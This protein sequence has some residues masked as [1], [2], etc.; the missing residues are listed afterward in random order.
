MD[1]LNEQIAKRILSLNEAEE[2]GYVLDICF[3]DGLKEFLGFV[4]CDRETEN[5]NFIPFTSVKAQ[6]Q[7]YLFVDN[8]EA[9]EPFFDRQTN[10]P[11]RKRV[12][13]N[14]GI[15]L[16][17]VNCVVL[18]GNKI[19][20]LVTDKCELRPQYIF[21]SGSGY[22][23]F[24]QNKKAAKIYSP[25]RHIVRMPKVEIVGSETV[26]EEVVLPAK[27]AVKPSILLNRTATVD[28]FGLNNELIIRKGE[29]IT[30]SKLEK[31]K[32]HN[33][34]NNLMFNSK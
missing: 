9:L 26:A 31:A 14:F 19:V 23:I 34:L 15:D 13:D 12:F 10:N 17:R 11:Y 22:I 8:V 32:K 2:L 7:E 4:V 30:K 3:D 24:S 1:N 28:I 33:K 18:Q 20:K 21:S 6:N 5:E 29:V 27:M 16:G 25:K